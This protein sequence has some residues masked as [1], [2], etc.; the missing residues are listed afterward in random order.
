MD[1]EMSDENRPLP[2]KRQRINLTKNEEMSHKRQQIKWSWS[3]SSY[4][5][6][7]KVTCWGIPL[8]LHICDSLDLLCCTSAIHWPLCCT[9][10]GPPLASHSNAFASWPLLSC[11]VDG[12]D[13]SQKH[14][15]FIFDERL[16][17]DSLPRCSHAITFSQW[18]Y[19]KVRQAQEHQ[20]GVH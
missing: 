19:L 20:G 11:A 9:F 8:V 3:Q 13:L 18:L 12:T 14:I 5:A 4:G 15:G 2:K 6:D 17:S 10:K 1:E 16:I 7:S